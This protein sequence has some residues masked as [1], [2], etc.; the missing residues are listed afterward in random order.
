MNTEQ[1]K[2]YL[3]HTEY[4]GNILKIIENN[5]DVIDTDSLYEIFYARKVLS[6]FSK[7][8]IDGVSGLLSSANDII[9]NY[10][11]SIDYNTIHY[12]WHKVEKDSLLESKPN[13][14]GKYYVWAKE[15]YRKKLIIKHAIIKGIYNIGYA[16]II[17]WLMHKIGISYD[18]PALTIVTLVIASVYILAYTGKTCL[19][20]L[21][22]RS[23]D[24]SNMFE[25]ARQYYLKYRFDGGLVWNKQRESGTYKGNIRCYD[26]IRRNLMWLEYLEDNIT[27]IDMN[28]TSGRLKERILDVH[29]RVNDLRAEVIPH[30]ECLKQ[31]EDLVDIEFI[32]RDMLRYTGK[33]EVI[34]NELLEP[35]NVLE[36]NG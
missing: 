22:L 14:D 24:N 16:G 23:V 27:E 33:N 2:E 15:C 6:E 20:I 29:N 12:T 31:V 11:K 9:S 3:K 35:V 34:L 36:V 5:G 1:L 19:D 8:R 28:D 18:I 30:G 4:I 10:I 21:K 17:A 32:W 25:Y 13:S 26:R 7:E